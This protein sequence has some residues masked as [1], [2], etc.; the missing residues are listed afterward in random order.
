MFFFIYDSV[1]H[2]YL[3]PIE[4]RMYLTPWTWSCELLVVQRIQPGFSGREV[5]ALNH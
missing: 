1:L 3:V 5:S 4:T 2:A